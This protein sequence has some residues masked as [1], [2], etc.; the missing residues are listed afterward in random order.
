M[1]LPEN[2]G[3]DLER[4]VILPLAERHGISDAVVLC[5]A[6]EAAMPPLL[7]IRADLIPAATDLHIEVLG[8]LKAALIAAKAE[9]KS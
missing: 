7:I 6:S 9:A 4:Q 8:R 2:F 5:R 1:N 3:A